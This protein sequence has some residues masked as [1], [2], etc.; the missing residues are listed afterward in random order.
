MTD[1][2]TYVG[3]S[4]FN[5]DEDETLRQFKARTQGEIDLVFGD[6]GKI[7]MLEEAWRDG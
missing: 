1:S 5:Q 6:A 4:I 7:E 3:I 2:T